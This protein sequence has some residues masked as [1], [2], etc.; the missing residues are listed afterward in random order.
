MR[1]G[2][3][4]MRPSEARSV[5]PTAMALDL[6]ARRHLLWLYASMIEEAGRRLGEG[7]W[8]LLGAEH[9]SAA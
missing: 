8:T 9:V 1:R 7:A 3:A 6:R 2:G 4:T 5:Q